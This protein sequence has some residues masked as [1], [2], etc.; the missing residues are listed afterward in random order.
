LFV[1]TEATLYFVE[2]TN[3]L[4]SVIAK[5]RHARYSTCRQNLSHKYLFF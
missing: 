4:D 3:P 5:L 1:R 2:E